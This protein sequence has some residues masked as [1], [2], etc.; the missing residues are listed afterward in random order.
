M[1]IADEVPSL[2]LMRSAILAAQSYADVKWFLLS[3]V[4][5]ALVRKQTWVRAPSVWNGVA[6]A[7]KSFASVMGGSAK[8]AEYTLKALL[9]LPA[10]QLRAVVRAAGDVV[11][12]MGKLLRSLSDEEREEVISGRWVASYQQSSLL[13]EGGTTAAQPSTVVDA[14]KNK[15]IKAILAAPSASTA[16]AAPK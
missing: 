7:A 6:Y 14:E 9:G 4:I 11:G 12:P 8:S 1:L 13:S 10:P 5:P 3:D 15:V 16:A 2:L